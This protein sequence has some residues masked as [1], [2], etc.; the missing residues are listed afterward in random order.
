MYEQA[1][2]EIE[3]VYAIDVSNVKG[4]LSLINLLF[5][6][7]ASGMGERIMKTLGDNAEEWQLYYDRLIKYDEEYTA[8]MKK[9]DQ[10]RTKLNEYRWKK[11]DEY[12]K[13]Q[14]AFETQVKDNR[15]SARRY[16][17]GANADTVLPWGQSQ[18][19]DPELELLKLKL[20][21]AKVYYQYI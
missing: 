12:I 7:D 3:K 1:R 19:T 4:R 11:S 2:R 21:Q 18:A 5:G 20:D 9:N 15:E 14:A 16:S 6:D 17:F 13:G 8:A 10:E